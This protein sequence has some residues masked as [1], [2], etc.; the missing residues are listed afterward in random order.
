MYE[1]VLA[2]YEKALGAE[3]ISTLGTVNN[4]GNL[5]RA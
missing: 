2:G 3:H 5:Y 1:R 4:F